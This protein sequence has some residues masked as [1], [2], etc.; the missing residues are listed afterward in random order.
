[1]TKAN[2]AGPAHQ[3]VGQALVHELRDE[4]AL[5]RKEPGNVRPSTSPNHTLAPVHGYVPRRARLLEEGGKVFAAK[6]AVEARAEV[7][8]DDK[9]RAVEHQALFRR[10]GRRRQVDKV[11][12]A[13]L[14][15]ES[16]RVNAEPP[17]VLPAKCK[18][19]LPWT[20]C[21]RGRRARGTP[22]R[23]PTRARRG[24]SRG[25]SAPRRPALAA[26][27][28]RARRRGPSAR[29]NGHGERA[30][31]VRRAC[32]VGSS[33][34]RASK[35]TRSGV[36]LLSAWLRRCCH[37]GSALASTTCMRLTSCIV[38]WTAALGLGGYPAAAGG[39]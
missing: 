38:G 29:G 1:M 11:D 14:P 12:L 34:R 23:R 26:P 13:N 37:S 33:A 22:A 25:V 4:V 20:P 18:P 36:G 5:L 6:A 19:G 39:G 9:G 16:S 21:R 27:V 7:Q 24:R 10:F 30:R 31:T 32:G 28:H 17:S 2:A 3:R 15:R 8:G 35:L